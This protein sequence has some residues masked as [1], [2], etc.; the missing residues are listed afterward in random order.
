[1]VVVGLFILFFVFG[2]FLGSELFLCIVIGFCFKGLFV[3][4]VVESEMKYVE[5]WV[6]VIEIKN[7][8]IKIDFIYFYI[9]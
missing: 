1:M 3:L 6:K 7:I 5:I 9:N 2:L 4:L 8:G